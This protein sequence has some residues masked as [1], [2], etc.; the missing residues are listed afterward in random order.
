MAILRINSIRTQQ[1]SDKM[2]KRPTITTL[3]CA[4][5]IPMTIKLMELVLIKVNHA[6]AHKI[7]P[8]AVCSNS[9]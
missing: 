2:D 4:A 3:L 7:L 1:L 9:S 5:A 8:L 6:P